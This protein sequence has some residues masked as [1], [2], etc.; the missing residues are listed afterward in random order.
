[1]KPG[2]RVETIQ[3]P[4]HSGVIV[5]SHLYADDVWL[6]DIDDGYQWFIEGEHIKVVDVIT[7]LGDLV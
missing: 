7:Q 3:E 1:M 4:W 5:R 6:V 2:D